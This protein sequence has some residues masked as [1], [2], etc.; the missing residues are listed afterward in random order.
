VAEKFGEEAVEAIVACVADDRANL[1]K[2]PPMCSII[3]W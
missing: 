3:C 2:R 1:T